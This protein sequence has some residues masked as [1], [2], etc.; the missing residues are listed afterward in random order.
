MFQSLVDFMSGTLQYLYQFTIQMG[1][2]S[3]ALAII[4]LTVIVNMI[5]YP[6]KHSQMKSMKKMQDLQP[7]IKEL[8]IKYK[9]DPQKKQQEMME[10][11]KQAGANPLAGCLPLIIQLP[12]FISLYRALIGF[13]YT[14]LAHASFFWIDNISQTISKVDP[15]YILPILVAATTYFSQKVTMPKNNT[16]PTQQTMLYVMP[17]LFGFMTVSFPAGLAIYWVTFSLVGMVQQLLIN[18]STKSEPLKEE[19]SKK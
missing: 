14:N 15:F 16:D 10:I 4:L 13:K 1:I 19:A 17:F 11:Y 2:P 18:H 6:L 7:K 5:L 12:I 9:N 8:D 3:Y